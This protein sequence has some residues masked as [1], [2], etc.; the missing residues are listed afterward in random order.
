MGHGLILET[1][2]LIDLE[3]DLRRGAQG[4]AIRWLEGHVE[5]ELYLTFTVVGELACGASLA[6]RERWQA[7]IAPFRV[8]PATPDVCWASLTT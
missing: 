5:D 2:F 1:T 8:L 3:R 4:A 7:F 6:E